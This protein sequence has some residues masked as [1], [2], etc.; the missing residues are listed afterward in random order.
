MTEYE[1]ALKY[2]LDDL[3]F[4]RFRF[5]GIATTEGGKWDGI[6]VFDAPSEEQVARADGAVWI[7]GSNFKQS[8]P[9]QWARGD[10]GAT[11]AAYKEKSAAW[12]EYEFD[13]TFPDDA[14]VYVWLQVQPAQVKERKI[15]SLDGKDL[16]TLLGADFV[17]HPLRFARLERPTKIAR[18]KHRLR[19]DVDDAVGATDPLYGIYLTTAKEPDLDQ[20]ARD[21]AAL[22]PAFKEAF[23]YHATQTADWLRQRGWLKKAHARLTDDVAV[24]EYGRIA[25]L[26][27][28]VGDV[29]PS[30]RR[31]LPGE[32]QVSLR[33]SAEVWIASLSTA[34]PFT[35]QTWLDAIKP[36]DE[37]WASHPTLHMLGYPPIATRLIPW[38]LARHGMHGYVVGPV[39]VRPADSRQTLVY[40]DPKTGQPI[41]S[42]RWELFR[43]GM[44]DFET[45]RMLRT[46][47]DEAPASA[48]NLTEARKLLDEE[49]PAFVR[50]ARDFSW[51]IAALESLRARAGEL[52]S[53]L[54][55]SPAP[56]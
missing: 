20:L 42:V 3:K 56:R 12:V 48:A 49:L 30:A 45:F 47:V 15:V 2:V 6:D 19:V 7:R 50:D 10:E 36:T 1:R 39:N 34:E 18:G 46:A 37:L 38:I 53:R 55:A 27:D 22:N 21:A 4:T 40:A 11:L 31:E 33:K 43:E 8:D 29:L 44:E 25:N 14:T 17:A 23:A 41:D 24:V 16:G 35:P 51:D 54:S 52:L 5:P 26:Y 9:P 13:S 28:F 32:P